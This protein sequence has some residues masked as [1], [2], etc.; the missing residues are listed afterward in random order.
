MR[1][2]RNIG[3]RTSQAEADLN[4]LRNLPIYRGR[5]SEGLNKSSIGYAAFPT[6]RFKA[7]QGAAFAV[8]KIVRDLEQRGLVR[9]LSERTWSG[10]FITPEG[11]Q[12]LKAHST[13]T[14][15]TP[16]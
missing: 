14:Q 15:K 9:R 5:A 6:Y 7:P 16:S 8:A 12:H 4:I 10:Y 13:N 1:N 11:Q 2:R 3:M